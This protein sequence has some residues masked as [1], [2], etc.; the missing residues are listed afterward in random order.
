MSK[1]IG[2][3]GLGKMGLPMARHLAAHG[4]CLVAYDIAGERVALAQQ[5]GLDTTTDLAELL[6]ASSVVISSLPHDAALDAT[7]AEVCRSARPGTIYIDTSTVSIEMSSQVAKRLAQVGIT[8]LRCTVSGNSLMAEAAELTVMISGDRDAYD[9]SLEL[10]KC[11]GAKCFYLGTAEQARLMKLVINLMIMLTSGMLAEALAL[12]RKGGLS[13]NDMW[14]VISESAVASPIVKAKAGPLSRR[15]FSPTFTVQQMQKDVGLILAA[16]T[17]LGVPLALTAL[18]AQWLSS[19]EA[20]GGLNEDY[21][22][23]IKVIENA[24]GLDSLLQPVS[25]GAHAPPNA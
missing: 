20:L 17:S 5:A 9:S 14:N 4:H 25:T 12:G 3:I 16:G 11:W 1:Q 10:V 6:G 22:F 13:W 19:A 8:Y 21:A 18:T 7:A 15:D 24:S 23:V 2:F